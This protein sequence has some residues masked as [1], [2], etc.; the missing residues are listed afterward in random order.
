MQ[1]KRGAASIIVRVNQEICEACILITNCTR[2][3][4]KTRTKKKKRKLPF[5]RV[6]KEAT[7]RVEEEGGDKNSPQTVNVDVK[8]SIF[9]FFKHS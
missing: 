8:A 7:A 2:A 1:L 6:K 5:T 4:L 9:F 3:I